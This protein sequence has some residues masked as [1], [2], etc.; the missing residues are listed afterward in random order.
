MSELFDLLN[1]GTPSGSDRT[2][3]RHRSLSPSPQQCVSWR[4]TQPSS[5]P[6]DA[7]CD[8]HTGPSPA[9]NPVLD[10][11]VTEQGGQENTPKEQYA[12]PSR[13]RTVR[14]RQ[15][16]RRSHAHPYA[17]HMYAYTHR[18]PCT[19]AHTTL[20][21]GDQKLSAVTY[22]KPSN[23]CTPRPARVS[24]DPVAGQNGKTVRT[25]CHTENIRRDG[26]K[27][28]SDDSFSKIFDED[29]IDAAAVEELAQRQGW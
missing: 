22:K 2:S 12:S 5:S 23:L 27:P 14:A 15:Q 10:L 21:Q 4:D 18:A 6:H 29:P 20:A 3:R 8:I 11:L 13:L 9:K 7:L 1:F 28:G 16:A 24:S 26:D 17:Y 25:E 19:S